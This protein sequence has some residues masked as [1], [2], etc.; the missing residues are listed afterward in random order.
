MRPRTLC[1]LPVRAGLYD[2]PRYKGYGYVEHASC[3]TEASL[4]FE[5]MASS[6]ASP[7]RPDWLVPVRRQQADGK[8]HYRRRSVSGGDSSYVLKYGRRWLAC[9]PCSQ[10]QAQSSRLKASGSDCRPSS[11]H[12]AV[13]LYI[14]VTSLRAPVGLGTVAAIS[15]SLSFALRAHRCAHRLLPPRPEPFD[16]GR[17]TRCRGSISAWDHH[18]TAAQ[19]SSRKQSDNES[20][21]S[22]DRRTNPSEGARP[23]YLLLCTCNVLLAGSRLR[24]A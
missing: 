24:G 12:S 21:S 23:V 7:S 5:R 22:P 13:A 19:R 17:T 4:S 11:P 18:S 2:V 20:F 9:G 6:T 3:G 16:R 1:Q 8:R 14:T 15:L 10:V